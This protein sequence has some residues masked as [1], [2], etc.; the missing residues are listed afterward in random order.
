MKTATIKDKHLR[1]DQGKIEK[2]KGILKTKTETETIKKAIE[3]VIAR[4]ADLLEK[5][6][7]VKRILARRK[8]I[9]AIRGDIVD[10]IMEGREGRDKAYGR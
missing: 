6:G 3:L 4:D 10:W 7:I 1:L 8:R 5:K 2:A 9:S